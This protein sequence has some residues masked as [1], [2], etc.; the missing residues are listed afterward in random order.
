MAAD[1][2][3]AAQLAVEAVRDQD[4]LVEDRRRL[5]VADPGQLIG[6]GDQL[7][8]A[9]EDAIALAFEDGLVDVGAGR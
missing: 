7:P 9:G 1:V 3:E 4:R 5:Q 6:T 2:V 8:G